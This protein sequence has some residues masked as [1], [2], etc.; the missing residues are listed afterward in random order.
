[1]LFSVSTLTFKQH[2]VVDVVT[3]LGLGLVSYW[4][5]FRWGTVELT[6]A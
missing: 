6:A 4:I 5:F 2:Y 1:M 3:G